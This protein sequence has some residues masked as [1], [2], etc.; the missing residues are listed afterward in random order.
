LAGDQG[1]D[2]VTLGHHINGVF[3][4]DIRFPRSSPFGREFIQM[5]AKSLVDAYSDRKTGPTF[6]GTRVVCRIFLLK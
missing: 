1:G 6:C 3:A 2:S 4:A 5:R